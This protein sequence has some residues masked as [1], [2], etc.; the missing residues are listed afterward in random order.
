M[1]HFKMDIQG[2]KD[3]VAKISKLTDKNKIDM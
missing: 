1:F 3:E 2:L